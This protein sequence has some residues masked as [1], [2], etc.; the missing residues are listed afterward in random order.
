MAMKVNKTWANDH[1]L[2]EQRVIVLRG[3]IC[4]L[5]VYASDL[6]F[7]DKQ[8]ANSIDSLGGV[9]YAATPDEQVSIF[10]L[11]VLCYRRCLFLLSSPV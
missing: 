9:D 2:S 5:C 1:S 8:V 6:A 3:E 7:D 11:V 10:I 4:L